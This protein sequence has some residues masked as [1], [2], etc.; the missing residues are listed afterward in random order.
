MKKNGFLSTSVIYSFF[1]VFLLLMIAL[2]M[3]F[4]NKIYLKKRLQDKIVE[5][6][7]YP[8]GDIDFSCKKG[9]DRLSNCLFKQQYVDYIVNKNQNLS[10]MATADF[11]NVDSIKYAIK[12]H[13]TKTKLDFGKVE[14][15]K[16]GMFTSNDDLGTSFYYRGIVEG[17]YIRFA[18]ELWLVTRVNGDG[19][20]RIIKKDPIKGVKTNYNDS[21]F[22]EEAGAVN[23]S[24]NGYMSSNSGYE[25]GIN[26]YK[27][28][29]DSYVKSIID[30]YYTDYLSKYSQM[31]ESEVIFC[32]EKNIIN[33]NS[34]AAE[35]F[36]SQVS[37]VDDFF[38]NIG[39]GFQTFK[40]Y[41]YSS[42]SRIVSNS[43]SLK[44]QL[45]GNDSIFDK[46]G[47]YNLGS[48]STGGS[49]VGYMKLDVY[50]KNVNKNIVHVREKCT[51][52]CTNNN[53]NECF[54]ASASGFTYLGMGLEKINCLDKNLNYVRFWGNHSLKF[55]IATISA[56]EIIMAGGAFGQKN[57]K[58]YLHNSS[59]NVWTMT[60]AMIDQN[61]WNDATV[62]KMLSNY[63]LGTKNNGFWEK[64]E[65]KRG[66]F[67]F[68]MGSD[69]GLY[70][71]SN[72]GDY[73]QSSIRPV[74]NLKKD[75]LYCS[76]IGSEDD[77]FIIGETKC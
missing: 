35:I 75:V 29:N 49:E 8:T 69:G 62:D 56:D 14:D 50:A 32:G 38:N 13:S 27:N 46:N 31:I 4:S 53:S 72:R 57:D 33:E 30:K 77:P 24:K 59:D 15:S 52:A 25:I 3:S 12:D 74:I 47:I 23:I 65:N 73:K 2:L 76:G 5:P 36:K 18:D 9:E 60:I 70:I 48:Y 43:P 68:V 45:T 34:N 67:Y 58:Y 63:V 28:E 51:E 6:K 20:I 11:T 16:V 21:T 71:T 55:P 26:K 39:I 10:Y 64:P 54:Q 40:Q 19:S 41:Y 61:G 7:T 37:K 44:C 1:I 17:N 66:A 22:D 42:M